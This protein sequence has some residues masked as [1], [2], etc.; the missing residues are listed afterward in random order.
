M[1]QGFAMRLFGFTC[2]EGFHDAKTDTRALLAWKPGEVLLAF[3]GTESRTNMLTGASSGASVAACRPGAFA[4]QWQLCA[5]K[6]VVEMLQPPL[7]HVPG[8]PR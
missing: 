7:L 2:F 8:P 5:A 6:Q 1:D 4:W 3:R